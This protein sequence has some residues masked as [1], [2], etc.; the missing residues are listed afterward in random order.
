METYNSKIAN[1]D[2]AEL[3]H[4]SLDDDKKDAV[5]WAKSVNFPWP[6]VLSNKQRSSGL[7]QYA[8]R[9]VPHYALIDKNG[10]QLATGKQ[11]CLQKIE[12]LTK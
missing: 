7:M 2:K 10:K 4:V 3:V 11:A 6:T 9:G 12:E 1:N 5:N 8:G